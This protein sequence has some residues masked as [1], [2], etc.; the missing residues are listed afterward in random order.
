MQKKLLFNILSF[1]L[2]L[3]ITA[4]GPTGATVASVEK[5]CPICLE[6][7]DETLPADDLQAAVYG[8]QIFGCDSAL[9]VYHA[10]C[11]NAYII[12]QRENELPIMCPVCRAH[13]HVGTPTAS[14]LVR[15]VLPGFDDVPAVLLIR[16]VINNNLAWLCYLSAQNPTESLTLAFQVAVEF[17]RFNIAQWLLDEARVEVFR[18]GVG[19]RM[20]RRAIMSRNWERVAW[21]VDNGI[22]VSVDDLAL[23][24]EIV[25]HGHP[26]LINIL[27]STVDWQELCTWIKRLPIFKT[28]VAVV[29]GAAFTGI[30]IK[31]MMF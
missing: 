29:M 12:S 21:L 20:V 5:Q 7:V 24:R 4:G 19:S 17:K 1:S 3:G 26:E 25:D 18:N 8:N 30:C 10:D 15:A 22:E 14:V 16:A 9:H 11:V 23:M 13:A 31:K 28:V 27:P 6:V 2:V